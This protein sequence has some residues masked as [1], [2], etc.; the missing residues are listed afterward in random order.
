MCCKYFV[1]LIFLVF[2]KYPHFLTTKISWINGICCLSWWG[3][4]AS[5]FEAGEK[6]G[7]RE[8][9]VLIVDRQLHVLFRA[10]EEK[11]NLNNAGNLSRERLVECEETVQNLRDELQQKDTLIATLTAQKAASD[12]QVVLLSDQLNEVRVPRRGEREAGGKENEEVHF[13]STVQCGP[14][15]DV[16]ALCSCWCQALQRIEEL[17]AANQE[18]EE[19]LRICQTNLQQQ[20]DMNALVG[21]AGLHMHLREHVCG[22]CFLLYSLV[23]RFGDSRGSRQTKDNGGTMK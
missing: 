15:H 18:C 11:E 2:G 19:N 6:E 14:G 16:L 1:Y 3:F 20:R 4:Y 9:V 17:E 23:K 21:V 13:A 22:N 8:C 7:E 5:I 12:Q 10:Q